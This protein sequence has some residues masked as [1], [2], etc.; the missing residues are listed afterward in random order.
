MTRNELTHAPRHMADS[1]ASSASASSVSFL[2][3]SRQRSMALW[4]IGMYGFARML[5]LISLQDSVQNIFIKVLQIMAIVLLTP[6]LYSSLMSNTRRKNTCLTIAFIAISAVSLL[7]HTYELVWMILFVISCQRIRIK[8]IARVILYTALLVLAVD[9]ALYGTGLTDAGTVMRTTGEARESLGFYHPNRLAQVVLTALSAYYASRGTRFLGV[10][11]I[12][13]SVAISLIVYLI[14]DSKT[15]VVGAAALVFSYTLCVHWSKE[16][17]VVLGKLII[18]L[19]IVSF[20]LSIICTIAYSDNNQLL[21]FINRLTS[22]R[23]KYANLLMNKIP[24]P[25]LGFNNENTGALISSQIAVPGLSVPLDNAYVHLLIITGIPGVIIYFLIHI[26]LL[27]SLNK[28]SD[29]RVLAAGA[30][31]C[32]IMGFSESYVIDIAFNFYLIPALSGFQG[33]LLPHVP[34]HF[35]DV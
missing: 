28:L 27:S 14:T 10:F 29:Y 16:K 1:S 22:D 12:L 8:D 4:A 17:E 2:Q 25:F 15:M 24:F 7:S 26:S 35:E 19:L 9:L 33:C 31:F 3:S 23:V 21:V 13:I 5:S 30:L 18:C 11:N 20:L 32:I 34:C 6:S